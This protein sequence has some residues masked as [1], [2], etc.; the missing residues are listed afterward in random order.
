LSSFIPM[1][2]PGNLDVKV[3]NQEYGNQTVRQA[4]YQ[5]YGADSRD[6]FFN[7][8]RKV[9]FE[10]EL[11]TVLLKNPTSFQDAVFKTSK[12]MIEYIDSKEKKKLG[13][14]EEDLIKMLGQPT[15]FGRLTDKIENTDQ[16]LKERK[17]DFK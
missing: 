2:L 13:K 10:A 14:A 1:F 17:G 3:I 8:K 6:N 11:A 5:L 4:V 7:P 15:Y 12:K 16:Y 9:D